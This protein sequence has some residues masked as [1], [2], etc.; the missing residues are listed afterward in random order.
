MSGFEVNT[1]FDCSGI[2]TDDKLVFT[3]M[4]FE[5]KRNKFYNDIIKPTVQLKRLRCERA[6]NLKTNNA[7]I[8]DIVDNIYRSRFLIADISDNNSNVLYEI[9]VAH[10][11]KKEI[12]MIYE[13]SKEEPDSI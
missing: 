1:T 9:G 8:R 3:L 2:D 12:I 5:E 4:H 10:A 11:M 6:D 7:I 13:I